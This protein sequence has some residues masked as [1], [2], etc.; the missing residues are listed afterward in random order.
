LQYA[1][2]FGEDERVKAEDSIVH[3][4]VNIQSGYPAFFKF[5]DS[6]KAIVIQSPCDGLAKAIQHYRTHSAKD[7]SPLNGSLPLTTSS[8]TM[9][10]GSLVDFSPAPE[11]TPAIKD[12]GGS[13]LHRP[14]PTCGK[15]GSESWIKIDGCLVC[16][17][18]GFSKC[19]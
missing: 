16:Q 6:D 15:C 1:A 9:S 19:G 11:A 10:A 2:E 18:C 17:G 3:Q 5:G 7:K 4:L 14:S 12:G 13:L 8:T